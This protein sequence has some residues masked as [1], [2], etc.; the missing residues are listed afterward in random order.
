M[1]GAR[2]AA[3]RPRGH[4]RA[5]RGHRGRARS[6]RAGG[7]LYRDG[8]RRHFQ[9]RQRG[10]QLHA[11]IRPGG[12]HDVDGRDRR[13]GIQSVGGVGRRRRG[14]YRQSSS[15]GDGVY[16]STDGGAHWQHMG[17]AE[18]RHIGRIA[19][20]PT[21]PNIVYVA[22]AGHLWGPNAERGVFKTTDGGQTWKKILYRDEN[23]GAIDLAMDPKDPNVLFAALYQ[24]QRKGWGFNGG[25]PGSGL[26]RTTDGGA[27]WTEL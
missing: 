2:M 27:T 14:R 8:Q 4:R 22:A 18:T 21:D 20:H 19:I 9:E 12:R 15:W 25:G 10:G 3:D 5:D 7:D 6:R 1:G 16:K 24:R 26:Y 11:R 13:G 23:T 17:L